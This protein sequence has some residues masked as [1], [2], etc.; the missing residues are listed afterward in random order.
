MKRFHFCVWNLTKDR[1]FLNDSIYD[2]DAYIVAFQ[3]DDIVEN[4]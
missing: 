2:G 1:G 3:A 4:D